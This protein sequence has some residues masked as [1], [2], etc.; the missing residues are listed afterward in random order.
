MTKHTGNLYQYVCHD[1]NLSPEKILHIGDNEHSDV[2]LARLAG[3]SAYHYITPL[4]QLLQNNPRAAQFKKLN[5]NKLG[6]SIL[7][8]SLAIYEVN[9]T[10][11]YWQDFGFQY[12]GPVVYGYMQW[13]VRQLEKDGIQNALFVARDGYSLQKVFD[14]IKNKNIKSHYFY[15]PRIVNLVCLSDTINFKN[16]DE[17]QDLK[18][19]NRI[20]LY[21]RSKD[22]FLAKNTPQIN[23]TEEGCKFMAA[24]RALYKKLALQERKSY[25]KYLASFQIADKK[26]ALIDSG[27]SLFSA[28]KALEIGLPDKEIH[29]YYWVIWPH[30]QTDQ[31]Q[32]ISTTFQPKASRKFSDWNMMEL[33]MTAPTPPAE[34]IEK[35]KVVFKNIT[36]QEQERIKIYPDLSAGIVSF[37][38]VMNRIFKKSELFL[39]ADLLTDWTNILCEIPTQTDKESFKNIM[40][41][42]DLEHQ[43]Y[44]PLPRPWFH[45]QV[46]VFGLTVLKMMTKGKKTKILL[47]GHLPILKIKAKA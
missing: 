22:A 42:S 41:A 16:N 19:L 9:K 35:S 30:P 11:N 37:A 1:L 20:L 5:A 47:F 43:D 3:L 34:K 13:L 21:F 28:Q 32:Y 8:G 39:D 14:I 24:N 4:S 15:A 31:S 44:I 12:A 10:G 29:G 33:F 38:H 2:S 7:L 18:T 40:H 45:R 36:P 27:T 17:K 26:V 23:N 25:Q 6:A 46:K